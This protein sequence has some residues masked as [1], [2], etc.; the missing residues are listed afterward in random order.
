M[1]CPNIALY[2]R[3][4]S[5]PKDDRGF[6][7]CMLAAACVS[8]A[9]P[10]TLGVQEGMPKDYLR[11]VSHPLGKGRGMPELEEDLVNCGVLSPRNEEL[12]DYGANLQAALDY[13]D[14][15][16]WNDVR[17]SAQVN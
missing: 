1:T 9:A 12:F 13:I 5:P 3:R 2:G 8:A 15:V 16:D 17:T 6:L 11:R 14:L 4:L 10:H 7:R